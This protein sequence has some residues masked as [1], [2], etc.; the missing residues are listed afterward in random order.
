MSGCGA[1]EESG[2]VIVRQLVVEEVKES[3]DLNVRGAERPALRTSDRRLP[4]M[5]PIDVIN[6]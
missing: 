3:G 5:V 4:G 2:P 1:E 6:N